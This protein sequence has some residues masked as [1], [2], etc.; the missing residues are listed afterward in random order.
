MRWKG[1][2][3]MERQI[4]PLNAAICAAAAVVGKKESEGP[5]G[6]EF[7]LHDVDDRFGQDTW[8]KAESEM[9]RRALSLAIDKSGLGAEGIDLLL[10]GDLLNQCI[11]SA[12]GHLEFGIPFLGLYGACSTSVEGLLLA[13][14]L[15]GEGRASA[16]AVGTSSH[17]C[18]AERQYRFPIEYGG[19]RP[20]T[21]QWT[22][23]GSGAFIVMPADRSPADSVLVVEG[24]VGRVVEKGIR[25]ANN[26][27]AAMAPAAIDTLTRYFDASGTC[28]EDFDLIVT[29]DLGR[30]GSAILCELM[31]AEGFSLGDRHTD[32]GRLIYDPLTQDVHAGGSGCGCCAVVTA[33]HFLPRLR[34]G[35]MRDILVMATGAMMSPDS[36]KQGQPIPAV[37]H[38]VRLQ[39]PRGEN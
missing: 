36:V 16:A 13:S 34:R 37:A 3:L 23:T 17:N 20:P 32:C 1:D 26:M 19:Q 31:A 12:Y 38:L 8:E 39:A 15:V 21:A 30:E 35:E 4:Y 5:L 9:Q 25:D 29:G 24:M 28:A 11:G 6:G 33:A 7:D 14:L 18:A 10:A 22:V 27:G 2:E